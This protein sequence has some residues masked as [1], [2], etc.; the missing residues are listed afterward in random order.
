MEMKKVAA[1]VE[2]MNE[3]GP[4]T[5]FKIGGVD[6]THYCPTDYNRSHAYRVADCLL[7]SMYV[8]FEGVRQ[9]DEYLLVEFFSALFNESFLA[10]L[11]PQQFMTMILNY[12]PGDITRLEL[13]KTNFPD[14]DEDNPHFTVISFPELETT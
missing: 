6:L 4:P 13:L 3:Y 7:F 14:G 11:T 10:S 12:N 2:I 5:P 8:I 9:T 1:Y